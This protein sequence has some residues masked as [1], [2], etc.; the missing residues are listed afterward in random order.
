M[1][2]VVT[3]AR[4][5][6]MNS[7]LDIASTQSSST[8]VSAEKLKVFASKV[9]VWNYNKIAQSEFENFRNEDKS[10]FLVRYYNES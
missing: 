9:P 1:K 2:C 3:Y 4:L 5:F 7:L 8:E 6:I 10:N